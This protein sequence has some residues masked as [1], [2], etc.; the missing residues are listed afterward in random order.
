MASKAHI[1]D[2][3]PE[4]DYYSC[5]EVLFSF[6]DNEGGY[7]SDK[8]TCYD[9]DPFCLGVIF[10]KKGK[11]VYMNGI[12]SIEFRDKSKGM[13]QRKLPVCDVMRLIDILKILSN[14]NDSFNETEIKLHSEEYGDILVERVERP[15][16]VYGCDYSL[17]FEADKLLKDKEDKISETKGSGGFMFSKL[18]VKDIKSLIDTLEALVCQGDVLVDKQFN[19]FTR[20]EEE[21]D[22]PY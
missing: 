18:E 22:F 9:M 21:I 8:V 6:G 16:G 13:S 10:T 2:Y 15:E 19:V 17:K 1:Y 7:V 11:M 4:Y 3:F 20:E 12:P 5:E 14:Q